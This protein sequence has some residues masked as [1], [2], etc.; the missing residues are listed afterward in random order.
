MA[1]LEY[2]IEKGIVTPSTLK[3]IKTAPVGR[4]LKYQ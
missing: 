2:L 4:K 3:P 1:F